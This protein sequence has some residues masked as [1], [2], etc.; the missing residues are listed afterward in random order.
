MSLPSTQAAKPK[1]HELSSA[2]TF[3]SYVRDFDRGY[4]SDAE[5]AQRK[6]LFAESKID[7]SM[8]LLGSV[9]CPAPHH[10]SSADSAGI[11]EADCMRFLV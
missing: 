8:C 4:A 6:G 11:A 7:V 3:E 9:R 2:Y 5:H 10:P 1:W